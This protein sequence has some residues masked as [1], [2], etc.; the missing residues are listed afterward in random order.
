MKK[1]SEIKISPPVKQISLIT[2]ILLFSCTCTSDE[3]KGLIPEKTFA[4]ILYEIHFADGL[5]SLPELHGKYY[6]R[7]SLANYTDIIEYHGYTSD[8][9][10]KTIKFYFINKPKKLIK[11]YDKTIGRLSEMELMLEQEI[12]NIPAIEAGLW[13]GEQA[14]H[15]TGAQDTTKIYFDHIFFTP[16]QYTFTFTLTLYPSDQSLNPRFT[17]FTCRADSVA[18]GKRN[19]IS[20]INYIKDGKPHTYNITVRIPN[21]LPQL[22]RGYILDFENNPMEGLRHVKVENFSFKLSSLVI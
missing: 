1:L 14:Y 2:L 19:Y 7:D 18:T 4:R 16:G 10:E 17:A 3:E 11:I 21:D 15:I 22:I 5:I 13:K 12:H 20:G 8:A 9:M 6:S